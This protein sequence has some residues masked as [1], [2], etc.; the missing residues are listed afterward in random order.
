MNLVFLYPLPINSNPDFKA[1]FIDA[2]FDFLHRNQMFLSECKFKMCE[3]LF[4]A[5]PIF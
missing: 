5:I 3:R 1:K 2:L 4:V